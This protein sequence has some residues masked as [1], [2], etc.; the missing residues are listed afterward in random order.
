MINWPVLCNPTRRGPIRLCR[1]EDLVAGPRSTSQ[2][3]SSSLSALAA[4]LNEACTE[5]GVRWA[6]CL[7]APEGRAGKSC[8]SRQGGNLRP[9]EHPREAI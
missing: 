2:E 6:V 3:F 8:R 7:G 4:R 5:R 1:L 9:F